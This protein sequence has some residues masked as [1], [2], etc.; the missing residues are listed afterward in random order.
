MEAYE[1]LSSTTAAD[2]I[3]ERITAIFGDI[4]RVRRHQSLPLQTDAKQEKPKQ[5]KKTP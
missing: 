1:A 5:G 3:Q 4:I 2:Y